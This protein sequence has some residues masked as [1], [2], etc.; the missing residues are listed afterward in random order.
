VPILQP[1]DL[2]T[3]NRGEAVPGGTI[4]VIAPGT[5]LGE[6]FLTWDGTGYRAHASEGGHADFA[7]MDATQVGLLQYLLQRSDHVSYE[8]VCSGIGI[9]NIYAYLK[10]S[11]ALPESPARAARLARA[12]DPTPVIAAAALDPAAPDPLSA[13]TLETFVAIL[14][15]EAGNLALKV[16]ATGGVYVAGGIPIHVAPLLE[17]GRFMRA[18][19]RKGRFAE[20]LS[21]VPVHLVATRAALI[22]AARYGFGLAPAGSPADV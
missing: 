6:A 15:A 4:A 3:L 11:G 14:G 5:G 17:D 10:D 18:F 13:A 2:R 16:L 1:D 20:L 7:P 22:G 21:G 12:A 19:R 8:H 9:P